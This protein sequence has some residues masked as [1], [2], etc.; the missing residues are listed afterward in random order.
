MD[1]LRER[2]RGIYICTVYIYICVC[3]YLFTKI[4]YI[5]ALF[6]ELRLKAKIK[7][8]NITKQSLGV[9]PVDASEK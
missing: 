2:E 4:I 6:G 3:V 1:N 7:M 5:Y 9:A 8:I